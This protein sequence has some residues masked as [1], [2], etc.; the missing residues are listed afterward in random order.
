MTATSQLDAFR[1]P[2]HVSWSR[3][4][5]APPSEMPVPVHARAIGI[6]DPYIEELM[7][8][9][10]QLRGEKV[11]PPAPPSTSAAKAAD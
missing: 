8:R 7:A 11:E 10:A 5:F 3:A 9:V 1:P 4:V 6:H 2:S